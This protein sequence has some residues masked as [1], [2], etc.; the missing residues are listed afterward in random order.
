MAG[1]PE[2]VVIKAREVLG[3]L[4]NGLG[5]ENIDSNLKDINI[6][7]EKKNTMLEL[8]ED[9]IIS[10]NLNDLTPI[11]ALNFLKEIEKQSMDLLDWEIYT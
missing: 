1:L 6:N 2:V 8:L 10:L 5:I 3:N 4:E 7:R 9:Q 11:E